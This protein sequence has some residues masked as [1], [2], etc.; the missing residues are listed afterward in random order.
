[1]RISQ[2]LK[3]AARVAGYES[4]S[5]L[6]LAYLQAKGKQ[7]FAEKVGV[8]EQ[9]LRRRANA[10]FEKTYQPKRDEMAGV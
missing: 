6:L 2:H 1:L 7:E 3:L 10:H 4:E 5:A 8:P 9:T